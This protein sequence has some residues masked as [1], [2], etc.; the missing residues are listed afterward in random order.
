MCM[1]ELGSASDGLISDQNFGSIHLPVE[2]TWPPSFICACVERRGNSLAAVG[3]DATGLGKTRARIVAPLPMQSGCWYRLVPAGRGQS[4]CERCRREPCESGWSERC[5]GQRCDSEWRKWRGWFERDLCEHELW[6]YA[7]REP[8]K[9]EHGWCERGAC[10]CDWRAVIGVNVQCVSVNRVSMSS[11]KQ[12]E[13]AHCA[14]EYRY[15]CIFRSPSRSTKT[16]V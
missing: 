10:E 4:E 15:E 1:P 12:C 8:K 3:P 6:E 11:A 2:L 9:W 13:R 14:C 5:E 7:K 16:L